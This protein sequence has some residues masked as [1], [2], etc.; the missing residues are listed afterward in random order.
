MIKKIWY[1]LL[2]SIGAMYASQTFQQDSDYTIIQAQQTT[3]TKIVLAL[4][5][6]GSELLEGI[7]KV[8]K[9]DLEFTDQLSVELV[10]Q[11]GMFQ[12]QNFVWYAERA[13]F[14]VTLNMSRDDEGAVQWR[15]YK[16]DTGGNGVFIKG[17]ETVPSNTLMWWA[18]AI[19]DEIYTQ[20]TGNA[21]PF[22]SK[23]AYCKESDQYKTTANKNVNCICV[24]DCNG[25][26]ENVV[27]PV[28]NAGKKIKSQ[29]LYMAPCW[30]VNTEEPQIL[31]SEYT[32]VNVRL[33]MVD[34][35]NATAPAIVT[36]FDGTN[37]LPTFSPDGRQ[38][39]LCL[40]VEGKS[41]IYRW[42]PKKRGKGG[43]YVKISNNNGINISP[44]LLGN[45]DIAFCSDYELNIPHIY[46]MNKKGENVTRISE[47]GGLKREATSPAYCAS[48][49]KIAY[50]QKV[51]G[52]FQLMVYD[53]AAD[54][55]VQ[56]SSDNRHKANPSWSP[57]GN[58][59]ICSSQDTV[60]KRLI[61]FKLLTSTW[62]FITPNNNASYTFPTW[63]PFFTA[64]TF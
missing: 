59:I 35:L 62:Q 58:Y 1:V 33:M 26:R 10:R 13:R 54:T 3:K 50:V 21:S 22:L 27:V 2:V 34:L 25:A 38:A 60:S 49:N 12:S 17:E 63:S 37:M 40:S 16:S 57:C 46:I 15:L 30:G 39:L 6:P 23:I 18:H 56:I 64:T 51:K 44:A 20:L 5:G 29:T 4:C 45:G 11:E 14:V 41:D 36:D 52:I 48:Q 32:N 7:G 9:E 8:I 55:T 61:C 42:V 53:I 31:Y 24:A 47:H 19:A 28:A 43:D